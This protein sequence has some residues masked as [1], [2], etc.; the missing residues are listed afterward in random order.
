M[1][2]ILATLW[3][4]QDIKELGFYVK[5]SRL[6]GQSGTIGNEGISGFSETTLAGKKPKKKGRNES[7]P[8]SRSITSRRAVQ[9]YP[10]AV[11][12]QRCLLPRPCLQ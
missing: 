8:K 12:L 10:F 1:K 2:A 3:E 4:L 6:S 7:L 11:R 9:I 5:V